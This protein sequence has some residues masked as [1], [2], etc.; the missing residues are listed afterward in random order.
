MNIQA[1]RHLYFICFTL[2]LFLFSCSEK[3]PPSA[4][5]FQTDFGVKDGA[6]SAMKGVAH[7]VNASI[8][9]YDLTHEI[10]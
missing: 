3:T 4:I 7:G 9:L 8:P 2:L 6:V 10:P 5:V 1:S